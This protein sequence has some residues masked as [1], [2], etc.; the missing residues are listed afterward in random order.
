MPIDL[1]PSSLHIGPSV[2]RNVIPL[3][4]TIDPNLTP[5]HVKINY[6]GKNEKEIAKELK[7]WTWFFLTQSN[8]QYIFIRRM[9][10]LHTHLGTSMYIT[11]PLCTFKPQIKT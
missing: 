8:C 4:L 9:Y 11:C 2:R 1:A 6:R 3:K 10:I 5:S 7:K